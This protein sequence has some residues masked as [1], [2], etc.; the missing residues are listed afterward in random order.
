MKRI[1]KKE[2]HGKVRTAHVFCRSFWCAFFYL[3]ILA[4]CQNEQELT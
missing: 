2:G 4:G 3:Y 1:K